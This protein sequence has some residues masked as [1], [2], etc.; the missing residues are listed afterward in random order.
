MKLP[1]DVA[2]RATNARI[3]DGE[4]APREIQISTDTRTLQAGEAFLALR[5][6]RF[7]GHE[8]VAQAV[9]CGANALIVDRQDARA[10][11]VPTLLVD[12]TLPAYMALARA[13]RERFGGRVVAI[14]GSTGKTTT[15]SLLEQMLG[16]TSRTVLAPP[17]NENNEIG[18]S[19]LL[20]SAS[21]EDV[22]IVEL[23]AR[24]PGDVGVLAAVSEPDIGVLTNIGEAHLE[25]M[26]SR[27]QLEETKWAIFSTGARAVLNL[28]DAA[29]RR[30]APSLDREPSWFL[31]AGELPQRPPERLCAVIGSR[32]FVR[33]GSGGAAEYEIDVRLP[34]AYNRSNLAA[35][36][37]AALELGCFDDAERGAMLAALPRLELPKGRYER[38]TLAGGPQL[39]YDAYNASASGMIATLDAFAHEP[40]ERRIALLSS[41]AELG[42]ESEL[43]HERVGERVAASADW[44]L[45]GGEYARDLVRGALRAGLSEKRIVEFRSNDEAAAWLREHAR[46]GDVVLLKGS[47]KY[48]LEEIVS[49]L[50]ASID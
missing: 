15:K 30:R 1:F 21:N 29:S 18:V 39:I 33:A 16:A 22:L 11:G 12:A 47:R 32:L 19:K 42:P 6:D 27:E 25:I 36:L 3:L 48:R 49:L 10:A 50:G 5:G 13:A 9:A 46:R 35:A 37:A 24:H 38:L 17:A 23:G 8:Y 26:G 43:L 14:T 2:A 41:M 20:L 34:G 31:S 28:D 45:A 7:D 4:R 40:A 44:L